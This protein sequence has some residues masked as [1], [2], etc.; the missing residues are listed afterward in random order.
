MG[1]V[2]FSQTFHIALGLFP[3]LLPSRYIIEADTVKIAT[4]TA[5]RAADN[6]ALRTV[7][8]QIPRRHRNIVIQATDNERTIGIAVNK[9]DNDFVANTRDIDPTK[10]VTRP[11]LAHA[12]PARIRFPVLAISIPHEANFYAT[13]FIGPD[14]LSRRSNNNCSLWTTCARTRDREGMTIYFVGWLDGKITVIAEH[15]RAAR[16]R[17]FSYTQTTGEDHVLPVRFLNG[18]PLQHKVTPT[19]NAAEFT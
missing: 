13:I 8:R 12:Q 19:D 9:V 2:V 6:P 17:N 4:P 3:V 5:H 1:F 15:L 7:M 11:C 16:L 14:L 18:I 10:V